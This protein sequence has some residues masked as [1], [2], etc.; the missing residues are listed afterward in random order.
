MAV[1]QPRETYKDR[2]EEYEHERAREAAEA[3]AAAKIEVVLVRPEAVELSTH[4]GLVALPEELRRCAGRVRVLRVE[5]GKLEA[6]PASA[7]REAARH[8]RAA[9]DTPTVAID[10]GRGVVRGSPSESSKT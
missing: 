8:R 9:S 7:R 2:V 1:P 6:L 4:K 3:R 10:R 5:S